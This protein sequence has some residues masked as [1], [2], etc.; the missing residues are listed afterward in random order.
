MKELILLIV[1]FLWNKNFIRTETFVCL[2]SDEIS[3]I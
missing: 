2:I 1:F 3:S